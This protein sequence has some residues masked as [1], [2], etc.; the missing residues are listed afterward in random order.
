MGLGRPVKL[1][2][3]KHDDLTCFRIP[4]MAPA[5]AIRAVLGYIEFL[6]LNG[7]QAKLL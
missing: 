5:Q 7:P 2:R 3:Q 6:E 1:I 4:K